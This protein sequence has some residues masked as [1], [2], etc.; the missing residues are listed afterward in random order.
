MFSRSRIRAH[1]SPGDPRQHESYTL[2]FRP[3]AREELHE[4]GLWFDDDYPGRGEC[5]RNAI[6]RE[7]ERV[8]AAPHTFPT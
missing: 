2:R 4:A 5:F 1:E 6:A 7:L 8:L 3:A